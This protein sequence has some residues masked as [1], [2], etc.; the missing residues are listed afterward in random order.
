MT[1]KEPLTKNSPLVSIVVLAYNHLDYTKLCIESLYRYTSHIDFEL[2]TINNG[3]TDQTKEYF[4]A[5]PHQKKISFAENI[6]VDKAINQGFRIAEGKYTVNVSNDL[7][8]TTNWLDN[9][10][11]CA[12]SDE[13]IGMVVPASSYSSNCQ[14]LDL[15]YKNLAEMQEMAKAHNVSSPLKWEERLRLITYTCLIRTNLQKEFG[16]FDED[17]NPGG[18]DDDALCFKVRRAG[19]KLILAMDTFVHHFGSVTF[20]V[21]YAKNDIYVKNRKLFND[22]FGVDVWSVCF[23]DYNILNL[24]SLDLKDSKESVDILGIGLS[25]GAT[26]L[27]LKNHLRKQGVLDTRLWYISEGTNNMADLKTICA[28]CESSRNQPLTE[29][30]SDK[31]FDYII[32]ESD[33]RYIDI[34]MYYGYLMS[35]LKPKGQMI[36]TANNEQ[37]YKRIFNT[38]QPDKIREIRNINNYYHSFIKVG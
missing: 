27:Q 1:V 35:R 38:V 36:F 19:Y 17:F 29:I 30:Y 32:V 24:A 8:L 14:Q 7:V 26:L 23:I 16:G 12:E 18:F 13:K 20:Q 4:E 21:E 11:I 33:S 15:G 3:S 25:C 37:I 5:L 6:G 2:I 34:Q 28:G 31:S 22:K 10:L 9:L